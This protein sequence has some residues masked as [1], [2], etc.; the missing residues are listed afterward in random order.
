[1][2][3]IGYRILF[4]TFALIWSFNS[5]YA[6]KATKEMIDSKGFDSEKA[7]AIEA[8][9]IAQT[10]LAKNKKDK[11]GLTLMKLANHIYP[12]YKP[13]LLLRAK[14]KYNLAIPPPKNPGA[15]EAEFVS[16]QFATLVEFKDVG[17]RQEADGQ[18]YQ[19]MFRLFHAALTGH[20]F[21][22]QLEVAVFKLFDAGNLA[23]DKLNPHILRL[24]VEFVIA[25]TEGPDIYV[26][27]GDIRQRQG[28][29][30]KLGVLD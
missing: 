19:V 12:A 29:H 4:L 18:D 13:L 26:V 14:L 11:V 2:I 23:F 6:E 17:V 16:F 5:V 21:V 8:T 24:G 10:K 27:D 9:I 28:T 30:S 15:G 25:F 22:V 20:I 7:I 1:M 3:N